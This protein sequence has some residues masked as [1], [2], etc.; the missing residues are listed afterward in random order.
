MGDP[1]NS[2]LTLMRARLSMDQKKR[3]LSTIVPVLGVP[4]Q[5]NTRA[6]SSGVQRCLKQTANESRLHM[7]RCFEYEGPALYKKMVYADRAEVP[8]NTAV[9]LMPKA[10]VK[11]TNITRV[12]RASHSLQ[13]HGHQVR[14]SKI[15]IRHTDWEQP[16][17]DEEGVVIEIEM[18]SS[19]LLVP[20]L[21]LL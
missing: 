3:V 18:R 1:V 12:P 15:H 4:A 11:L 17:Q 8:L 20:S 19:I 7:T 21:E 13:I 10:L 9:V 6:E 14:N 16:R 2:S 5:Y